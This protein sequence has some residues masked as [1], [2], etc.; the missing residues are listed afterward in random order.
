MS[1]IRLASRSGFSVRNINISLLF[2][3]FATMTGLQSVEAA[4]SSPASA[5]V[6][7]V[8]AVSILP[9]SEFVARIAGDKVKVL[10]LVGPGASPHNYEPTP[11]QM[12]ELSG[13]SVWLSIGVEFEKALLPKI[14]SL[15]PKLRIVDT[16]KDVVYR[17]LESHDHGEGGA[18][19]EAGG[20][21]PH[22]WLGRDAVK[23]QLAATRDALI[24]LKPSEAVIFS[25]NH[26]AY[27]REIDSVFS[28][29]AK[30]LAPLRG[31]TAFVYHPSFGYFLDNFG[32]R[33]EAVEVGGK[34]PTQKTLALLIARARED[35]AKIIFVQKQFS[36]AAART[37]AKA[38]DGIVVEIDPLAPNWIENIGTMGEALRKTVR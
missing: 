7:P 1:R 3:A 35:G 13:A 37:V 21:D 29:L 24:A 17:K 9:Q 20:L 22:V 8:I 6:V 31:G 25:A 30:E 33:Q 14:K 28:L 19:D 2:L 27:L 36:P 38:I 18:V 32:I 5:P 16:V 4:G 15:Y 26:D 23:A 34:E 10:T 11:R 12:A